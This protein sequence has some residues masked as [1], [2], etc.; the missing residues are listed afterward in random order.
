LIR[1]AQNPRPEYGTSIMTFEI[2]K[3]ST[4]EYREEMLDTKPFLG[5]TGQ[6]WNEKR[7]HH[8]DFLQTGDSDWLAVADGYSHALDT[9]WGMYPYKIRD[10]YLQS[11]GR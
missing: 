4:E 9:R 5:P 10:R 3:L 6:G 11:R 7:M 1:F 8:V 2:G